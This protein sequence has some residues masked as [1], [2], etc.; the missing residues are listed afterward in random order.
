MSLSLTGYVIIEPPSPRLLAVP[1]QAVRPGPGYRP[2]A[3]RRDCN[4]TGMLSWDDLGC[5]KCF[6]S[7]WIKSDGLRPT[8]RR[9]HS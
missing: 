4:M 2:G 9:L 5:L 8:L 7:S 6:K 3:A 1:L